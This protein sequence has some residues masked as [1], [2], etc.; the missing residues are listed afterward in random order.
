MRNNWPQPEKKREDQEIFG[1][2]RKGKVGFSGRGAM[3]NRIISVF[4]STGWRVRIEAW[5]MHSS[6]EV[7]SMAKE[8]WSSAIGLWFVVW[9]CTQDWKA[10]NDPAY[11]LFSNVNRITK[12]KRY[13]RFP[14][15][16]CGSKDTEKS[17]DPCQGRRQLHSWKNHIVQLLSKKAEYPG[18]LSVLIYLPPHLQG[19][20]KS[21]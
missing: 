15:M 14:V 11:E 13:L 9:C 5:R 16:V 6:W 2:R 1:G 8:S 20:R 7:S 21:Q 12:K 19:V 3:M 10:W 4:C 17:S 18:R